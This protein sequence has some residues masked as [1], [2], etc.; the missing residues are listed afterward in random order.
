MAT[1]LLVAAGVAASEGRADERVTKAANASLEERLKAS[2]DDGPL[3]REFLGESLKATMELLPADPA[4]A[5]TRLAAAKALLEQLKPKSRPAIQELARARSAISAYGKQVAL[6]RVA[7]EELERTLIA[8]PNDADAIIR[9]F[10]KLS[11]EINALARTNVGAAD[12]KLQAARAFLATLGKNLTEDAA[13]KQFEQS[14]KGFARLEGTVASAKRIQALEGQEHASL[15]VEAWLNGSPLTDADLQGKVVLLDFWAVWC[16]PCR[17]TFPHLRA[18]NDKWADKG[19]VIIGLTQ[20]Y[21]FHWDDA[22]GRVIRGEGKV[23]P[24]SEREMLVKFA[25]KHDLRH[26]IA[27]QKKTSRVSLYYG[28]AGI[29]H[30]VVIDRQGKVRMIRAGSGEK[31]TQE[32]GE[33]LAKLVADAN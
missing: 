20:Y 7:L 5:D 4:A 28:V 1:S 12:A 14:H 21:N 19:L 33:L 18:W 8:N 25:R 16:S 24:E 30:Y 3:L 23:A 11:L 13:K 22:T 31:H 10:G 2:P 32:I 6:A 29:P 17:T 9:Y 26:R 27:L 15:D